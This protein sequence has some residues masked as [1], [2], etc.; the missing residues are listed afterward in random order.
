MVYGIIWHIRVASRVAK[1]LDLRQEN[2]KTSQ[3][4]N[5]VPSLPPQTNILLI[6]AKSC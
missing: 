1:R 4:D 5:L 3:N 2:L 6:L